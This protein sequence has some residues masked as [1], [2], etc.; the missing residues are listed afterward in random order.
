[1]AVQHEFNWYENDFISHR[2]FDELD[3]SQ[4]LASAP[5]QL[6]MQFARRSDAS[7]TV[8]VWGTI[9]CSV[10]LAAN[11]G[12]SAAWANEVNKEVKNLALGRAGAAFYFLFGVVFA[13][14]VSRTLL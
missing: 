8:L 5:Q 14:T 12:F 1:M 11:A 2:L 13:F 6:G 4:E 10:L 9:G 3:I 7:R